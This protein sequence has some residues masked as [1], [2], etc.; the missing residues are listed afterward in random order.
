MAARVV[1]QEGDQQVYTIMRS[2]TPSRP[3]MQD[4]MLSP[5]LNLL[6]ASF[7]SPL[8]FTESELQELQG[9][10]LHAAT[11]SVYLSVCIL[12]HQDQGHCKPL[13]LPC[14]GISFSSPILLRHW[15]YKLPCKLDQLR[16]EV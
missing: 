16:Q 8:H 6:P 9:T 2:V 4:S 13:H 15:K 3:L 10:T 1:L 12:L 7:D 5:W 11:R 14:T